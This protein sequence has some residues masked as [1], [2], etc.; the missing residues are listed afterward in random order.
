MIGA[1][2]AAGLAMTLRATGQLWTRPH[3]DAGR[4]V[5]TT[6]HG[7]S[8]ALTGDGLRASVTAG[9]HAHVQ[10]IRTRKAVCAL[11]SRWAARGC[12]GC[13]APGGPRAGLHGG[14]AL[15]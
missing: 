7:L 6:A 15:R 12:G 8:M 5:E 1:D 9:L 4:L 13:R 3:R 2:E 11:S 10:F 14:A